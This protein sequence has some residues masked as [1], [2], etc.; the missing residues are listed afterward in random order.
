MGSRGSFT[1]EGKQC[2]FNTGSFDHLLD[3]N[4]I[5]GR[6]CTRPGPKPWNPAQWCGDQPSDWDIATVRVLLEHVRDKGLEGVVGFELGN[7]LF[8]PPHIA[9]ETAHKDIAAFAALVD[10]VWEGKTVRPKLFATGTNDCRDRSN[11]DTMDVLL[12]NGLDGFSFHSYP[13]NAQE[14]SENLSTFLLNSSWLPRPAVLRQALHQRR[15]SF[16]GSSVS[17]SWASSPALVCPWSLA[18]AS[19]P[20]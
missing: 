9:V 10:E 1:P 12:K 18:G 13:G 6:T 3:V 14:H 2:P 4:E 7:E 11:N 19:P 20:F 5:I 8:K 15:T 17:R 16:M